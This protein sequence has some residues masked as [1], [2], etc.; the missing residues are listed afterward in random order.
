LGKS[1]T[2]GGTCTKCNPGYYRDELILLDICADCPKGWS[3][4]FVV[5]CSFLFCTT[6][7]TDLSFPLL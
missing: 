1:S 7:E 3:R 2:E 5:V 4:S 6:V